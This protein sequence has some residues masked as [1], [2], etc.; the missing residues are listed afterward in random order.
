VR[1]QAVSI[2]VT[3]SSLPNIVNVGASAAGAG[4]LASFDKSGNTIEKLLGPEH[5]MSTAT[6][7]RY[8]ITMSSPANDL[9]ITLRFTWKDPDQTF[10]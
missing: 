6:Q 1:I 2:D 7:L 9:T 8:S 4:G 10:D 5:S 3:G